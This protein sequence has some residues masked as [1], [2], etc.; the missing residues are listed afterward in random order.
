M[1]TWLCRREVVFFFWYA[2]LSWALSAL[3]PLSGVALSDAGFVQ[4]ACNIFHE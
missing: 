2:A 1:R 3:S 4:T